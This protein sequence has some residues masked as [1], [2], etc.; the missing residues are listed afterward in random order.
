MNTITR[1]NLQLYIYNIHT[2]QLDQQTAF[3]MNSCSTAVSIAMTAGEVKDF[4]DSLQELESV[5]QLQC[6]AVQAVDEPR[7]R[8]R[9]GGDELVTGISSQA[10]VMQNKSVQLQEQGG[11]YTTVCTRQ[12]K[13]QCE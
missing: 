5:P 3:Y 11:T 8:G 6:D 2:K 1:A 12:A 13:Y 4:A 7:S 10:R 9:S